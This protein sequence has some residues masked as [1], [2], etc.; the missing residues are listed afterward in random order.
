MCAL[1]FWLP[2]EPPEAMRDLETVSMQKFV[3]EKNDI[4]SLADLDSWLMSCTSM[5][6]NRRYERRSAIRR[7][8]KWAGLPA[9]KIA[10]DP[11]DLRKL[12][13]GFSPGRLKVKRK[14]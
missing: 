14:S 10:V 2:L 13:A 6:S 4:S 1:Q 12:F 8:S 5:Q 7:T 11:D 9:S 3:A